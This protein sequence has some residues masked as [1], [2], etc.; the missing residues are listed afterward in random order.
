MRDSSLDANATLLP[1][2]CSLV[3]ILIN[4]LISAFR[5][6]CEIKKKRLKQIL[7]SLGSFLKIRIATRKKK[8]K[9]KNICIPEHVGI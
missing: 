3:S 9:K 1:Q 2:K 7:K 4:S 5:E 6:K 8:K